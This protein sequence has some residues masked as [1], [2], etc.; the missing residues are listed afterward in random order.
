M[1]PLQGTVAACLR[2]SLMALWLLTARCGLA[3]TACFPDTEGD[4]HPIF[5]NPVTV[6]GVEGFIGPP[7]Y[8]KATS[9]AMGDL[10][11]DGNADAVVTNVKP[12]INAYY[13]SVLMGHGDGVFDPPIIYPGGRECTHVELG[14]FDRDG[15]LDCAVANGFDDTVSF[16]P[17]LGDGRLG[18]R[19]D[20]SAGDMPRSVVIADF[21][22][23]GRLDIISLNTLSH[24]VSILLGRG[25]GTFEGEQRVA[26][27][28]GVTQRADG[29]LTFPYPGP[30]LASADFD[31]DGDID[32]AIPS[33]TKLRTLLNDGAAGFTPGAILTS[34]AGSVYGVVAADLNGDLRPDLASCG[35]WPT[36]SVWL[37]QGD[38]QWGSVS[39]YDI[40]N[41]VGSP[42]GLALEYPCVAAGD[43]DGDG[44]IDLLFAEEFRHSVPFLR[45]RG[46]G[47]FATK[48]LT[49]TTY[50]SWFVGLERF[51]ASGPM[52]LAVIT[53]DQ[54]GALRTIHAEASGQFVGFSLQP[55]PFAQV[56]RS[57]HGA[58]VERVAGAP[59]SLVATA[60]VV[61]P[62][63]RLFRRLPDG[64]LSQTHEFD[65][66]PIGASSAYRT[67]I[68]DLDGVNGPDVILL[69]TII[70]GG[71][72]QPGCIWVVRQT[73]QGGWETPERYGLGDAFPMDAKLADV[74]R[75]G[76]LDMVVR[77]CQIYQGS[78]EI[79]IAR[80]VCVFRNDGAGHFGPR[81]EYHLG[82][83]NYVT[84]QG[85]VGL[86]RVDADE[87]LDIIVT[88]GD[89][90]TAGG[91]AVLI[92]KGDGTFTQTRSYA[93][94]AFP[95]SHAVGDFNG[96]GFADAA[97]FFWWDQPGVENK[98]V[99]QVWMND[100]QGN[101]VPGWEARSRSTFCRPR[102]MAVD[103]DNDGDLDLA[104]TA[105]LVGF[106]V[107]LNRGDGTFVGPVGY[108]TAG[109]LS[110]GLAT[111]WDGD[112]KM[113]LVGVKR[114][115]LDSTL[116]ILI[117]RGCTTCYANCDGSQT[118]PKLTVADF[119]C[120]LN[121]YAAGDLYA[122]CDQSTGLPQ[123][124]VNDFICFQQRF[125]AG[126]P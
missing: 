123:L 44:D 4:G 52:A 70:N 1:W 20:Y 6:T 69:D 119:I 106:I 68:G 12:P 15:D 65:F 100:R 35:V 118:P 9:F 117:N 101:L 58:A 38:G 104:A 75:D 96:D 59:P 89:G 120:F 34:A 54:R 126:C 99:V 17:N 26:V 98:L 29:N 67:E 121:R 108:G 18:P 5:S 49:P 79:P 39:G 51:R 107:C 36:A 13:L 114:N 72:D 8:S 95:R 115:S 94:D 10:N 116:N 25:D 32:L 14:D 30:F 45:N 61:S 63:L 102:S 109:T 66:G 125:L 55:R 16:F 50:E 23:D 56:Q 82:D 110:D 7:L 122:N 40:F 27:A 78:P 93:L 77:T 87:Y 42:V 2:L 85:T 88:T 48:E 97:A 11:G 64:Y 74:D 76:D 73:A 62:Q 21:N 91:L 3:Q 81:Q 60:C 22:G 113:D 53:N 112:G 80:R 28:G 33:G 92:N 124:T 31:S 111:D 41:D 71:Y 47:T 103:L 83:W 43:A 37:N 46:D 86:G 90:V 19:T 105:D 57:W 24:D 84:P